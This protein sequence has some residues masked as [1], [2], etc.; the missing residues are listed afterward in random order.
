MI[1]EDSAAEEQRLVGVNPSAP[2]TALTRKVLRCAVRLPMRIAAEPGSATAVASSEGIGLKEP[3]V[4]HVAS[5][6]PTLLL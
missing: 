1:P 3:G 2:E 5:A 6:A 4:R